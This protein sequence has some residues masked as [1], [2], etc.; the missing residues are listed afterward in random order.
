MRSRLCQLASFLCIVAALMSGGCA[1]TT[2]PVHYPD[3]W[4]S[5]ESASTADG[6]PKLDGV[7]SNSG[8]ETVPAELGAPPKLTEVFA[9]MG[10]SPGPK[11][12]KSSGNAWPEVADADYVLIRQT[13]E[14]MSVTFV[15]GKP[16]D[17]TLN[18][19]RYHFNWFEKRYDDLFTC[20]MDESG[21]RL[22]FLVEPERHS[23]VFATIYLEAGATLV[24]LLKASDGSLVVQWRSESFAISS[25]L[26]G[27]HIR[28]NSVWWRF[29]A[30]SP[31]P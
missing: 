9:R 15:G 20:Y 21:A 10:R 11:G 23:G 8:A 7:Y 18:F 5:I 28:F 19:R 13:P 30:R 14:A 1:S 29:P 3:T 2:G 27:S 12:P 22:R 24:F 4:A 31:V 17:T 26:V 6:C 16:E 25:V